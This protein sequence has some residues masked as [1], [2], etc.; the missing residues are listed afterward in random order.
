MEFVVYVQG[1]QTAVLILKDNTNHSPLDSGT[2]KTQ[3]LK[4]LK[5][6]FLVKINTGRNCLLNR[7]QKG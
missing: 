1:K 6:Y 3:V 5:A 4:V 2:S 7:S